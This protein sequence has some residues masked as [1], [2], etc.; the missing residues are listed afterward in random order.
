M[1]VMRAGLI[2]AAANMASAAIPFALLPLLTRALSPDE[3]GHVVAFSM[4]ITLAMPFAGLNVHSAVGVAWFHRPAEAMGAY[5]G[6]AV[7]LALVT[8]AMT[9]AV[10]AVAL[11]VWPQLG[12]GLG[13]LW[14]VLGAVTAGAMVILQCRLVLWQSQGQ[15]MKSAMLQICASALNV[16]LSLV[17]VLLLQWGAT[18]RNLGIAVSA[19]LSAVAA[20]FLLAIARDAT[21]HPS[22]ADA[23]DLVRYGMP[24]IP[25][26]FAGVLIGTA[27]RWIVS[28]A[29]GASEL[30]IYG[31]GAQLG[32]VMTLLADAFVKTLA[33]WLYGKLA[34]TESDDKLAAVGAVYLSG[35]AFLVAAV[36]VG[37]AMAMFG[38][39]LL[40]RKFEGAVG[41]LPWFMLA[42]AFSGM[43]MSTSSIFFFH[44]RT[45][46]LA[47]TTLATA[48][49][50]TAVTTA[51]VNRYGMF[52][53]A[54]G[55]VITQMLLALSVTAMAMHTFDLPW[56]H[57]TRSL[58]IVLQRAFDPSSRV[59]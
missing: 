12:S 46:L 57:A 10:A 48:I 41:L 45:W 22:R 27:D 18:G 20:V 9:A 11:K 54:I 6:T 15:A 51:L 37:V 8:S 1:S 40:G 29:L 59:V 33:P 7:A 36:A 25:H 50:G 3:Y 55:Y 31:A 38:G 56:A 34:S 16:G 58:K 17:G 49:V 43:Y 23:N 24:L 4:L 2:Y 39:L 44:K 28:A 14:G 52:G 32:M 5:A 30:G 35:P 42:G 26:V 19:W 47:K 53:A 13:P 21:W